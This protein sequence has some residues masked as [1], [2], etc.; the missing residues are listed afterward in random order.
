VIKIEPEGWDLAVIREGEETK[1]KAEVVLLEAVV[2]NKEFKNAARNVM[3][4][5]FER[6]FVLLNII[7]HYCPV[8]NRIKSIV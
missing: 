4:E 5:M 7:G 8:N 2:M 3:N 1:S 6:Q